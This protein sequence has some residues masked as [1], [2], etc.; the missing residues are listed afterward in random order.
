MLGL[1]D[2]AIPDLRNSA[3]YQ[4]KHC[5]YLPFLSEDDG[6][7]IHQNVMIFKTLKTSPDDE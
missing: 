5:R 2:Q 6:R 3:F 7:S 1:V 4:I